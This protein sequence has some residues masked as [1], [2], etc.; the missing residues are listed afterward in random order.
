MD[1]VDIFLR[2]RTFWRIKF[3]FAVVNT[4]TYALRY[5]KIPPCLREFFDILH[6]KFPKHRRACPRS[7]LCGFHRLVVVVAK[8]HDAFYLGR[9][10]DKPRV[11]TLVARACLARN[12]YATDSGVATCAA[13]NDILHHRKGKKDLLR[14]GDFG[15]VAFKG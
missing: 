6:Q 5:P 11:Y 9:Y 1:R 2:E 10:A 12:L 8:P 4:L 3:A 7:A 14:L 13:S 15:G